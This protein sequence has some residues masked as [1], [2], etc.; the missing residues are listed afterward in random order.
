MKYLIC[1]ISMNFI[2]SQEFEIDGNLKIEGDI[3]F[4][5]E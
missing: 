3:V 5:D 2:F 1:F 4:S